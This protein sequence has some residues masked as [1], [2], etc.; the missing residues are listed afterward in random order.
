MSKLQWYHWAVLIVGGVMMYALTSAEQP[1][2][3]KAAK[4]IVNWL[5]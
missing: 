1:L 4:R 5:S 3:T 2:V